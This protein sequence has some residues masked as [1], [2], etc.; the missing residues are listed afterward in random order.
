LYNGN[1]KI[2]MWYNLGDWGYCGQNEKR[3]FLEVNPR[4]L[5][6]VV[7]TLACRTLEYLTPSQENIFG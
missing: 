4:H 2:Y 5:P 6:S 7:V 1:Q 3:S